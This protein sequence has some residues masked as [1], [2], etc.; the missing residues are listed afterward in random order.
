MSNYAQT[1][2]GIPRDYVPVTPSDVTANMGGNADSLV[3]GFYATGTGTVSF[4]NVDNV[5]RSVVIGNFQYFPCVGIQRINA[6]GT[7]ATGLHAVVI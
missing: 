1:A 6:T 3:I 7:T 4:Q 5:A 2:V